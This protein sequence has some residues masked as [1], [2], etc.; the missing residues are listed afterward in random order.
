[1]TMDSLIFRSRESPY[2]D[3]CVWVLRT[4][5]Y[6][7]FY[8]QMKT[9]ACVTVLKV[10]DYSTYYSRLVMDWLQGYEHALTSREFK[11][12]FFPQRETANATSSIYRDFI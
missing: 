4:K 9:I 10:V 7:D 3:C 11:E 12:T 2:L 5:S 6:F 8:Y 1:M